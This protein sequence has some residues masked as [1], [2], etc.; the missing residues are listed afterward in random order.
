MKARDEQMSAAG[1]PQPIA[2]LPLAPYLDFMFSF[3]SIMCTYVW[4]NFKV[5][6]G[7]I[8]PAAGV[9]G[10]LRVLLL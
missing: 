10:C 4:V 9:I 3:K 6:R 7:V 5:R 8:Y 1:F 2:I